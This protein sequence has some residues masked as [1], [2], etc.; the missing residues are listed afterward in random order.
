MVSPDTT[1]RGYRLDSKTKAAIA[2]SVLSTL[3]QTALQLSDYHNLS[4]AAGLLL[5]MLVP[6]AYA[7]WHGTNVWREAHNRSA[8]RLDPLYVIILGLLITAGG[9]AWQQ[10][11]WTAPARSVSAGTPPAIVRSAA[12]EEFRRGLRKL[13]L[14]KMDRLLQKY[15]DVIEDIIKGQDPQNKDIALEVFNQGPRRDFNDINIL[16]DN[17]SIDKINTW[18]LE[19]MIVRFFKSYRDSQIIVSRLSASNNTSAKKLRS[20]DQWMEADE[21]CLVSIRD[22]K[23]SPAATAINEIQDPWMASMQS[24]E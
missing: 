16:M 9:V 11:W 12:E 20:F 7:A 10:V 15:R 19:K 6:A 17:G 5:A 18:D 13:I 4:L 8:L 23:S 14:S 1:G 3:G 2:V 21:Q 24:W 22:L